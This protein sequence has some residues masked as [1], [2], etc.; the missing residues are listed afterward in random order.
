MKYLQKTFTVGGHTD[1]YSDG[2]ERVFGKKR[3]EPQ[4]WRKEWVTC[5][6]AT[7]PHLRCD[8]CVDPTPVASD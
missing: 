2:W 6:I 3:A 4:E 7:V 5:R 8:I 1:A